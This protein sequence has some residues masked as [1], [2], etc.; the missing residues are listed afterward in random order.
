[1][2]VYEE[3]FIMRPN[4]TDEEIDP[5]VEQLTQVVTTRGGTI[6]KTDKWGVRRLAYRVEKYNE[7]YYVLLQFSAGPDVV[8][9]IERRLRVA[10]SVMKFITVRIDEKMK[11]VEKRRKAREKRA[12]RK[13]APAAAAPAIPAEP[14]A[15][16]PGAPVP[17]APAA[18][19]PTPGAPAPGAPPAPRT[20]E[21]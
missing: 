1:M 12:A 16:V 11:K 13:P 8:K 20:G 4:A 21:K 3:L 19:G 10:D 17:A 6:E 7:G 15:P 14:G 5:F 9:E 18:H 2:R